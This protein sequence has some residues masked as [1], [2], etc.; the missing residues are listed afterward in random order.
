[1]TNFSNCILTLKFKFGKTNNDYMKMLATHNNI[2]Y[3]ILPD[4]GD[5]ST[6][7]FNLTLPDKLILTISNKSE[8]DTIIDDNGTILEDRYIQLQ[9]AS[10]DGFDLNYNFLHKKIKLVT[11]ENNEIISS[12]FGFNGS[13]EL[14]FDQPN[15]FQQIYS[16]NRE[17]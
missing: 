5:C 16:L 17:I 3:K 8:N 13:V 14:I 10:I 12:Y 2:E 15:V 7:Q 4:I 1:M 11:F 6:F 9:E